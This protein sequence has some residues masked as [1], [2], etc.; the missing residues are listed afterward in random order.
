MDKNLHTIKRV[1]L[2]QILVLF[3]SMAGYAFNKGETEKK[4]EKSSNPKNEKEVND[5]LNFQ[6]N[7]TPVLK[8]QIKSATYNTELYLEHDSLDKPESVI[9]FNFIQYIIQNYKFSEEMF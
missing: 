4:G 2:V 9:T 6:K 3:L 1:V 7:N 8:S 5:S